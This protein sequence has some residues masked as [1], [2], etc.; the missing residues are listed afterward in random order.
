MRCFTLAAAIVLGGPAAA[1]ADAVSSAY[2][3][4]KWIDATGLTSSPCEVFGWRSEVVATIDMTTKDAIDTCSNV[5]GILKSQGIL[6]DDGWK[7]VI[8]SPYI[9]DNSIAFCDLPY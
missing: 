5:T 6:F 4:C 3:T 2:A 8:K 1:T 9:G 7:L